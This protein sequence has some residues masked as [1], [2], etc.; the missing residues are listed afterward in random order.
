VQAE[1]DRIAKASRRA[2]RETR[3]QESPTYQCD[4]VILRDHE[5]DGMDI[6]TLVRRYGVSTT[7]VREVIRIL[8]YRRVCREAQS[9]SLS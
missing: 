4:R 5:V 9:T 3:R 6:P 2:L 8:R 1:L 7:R